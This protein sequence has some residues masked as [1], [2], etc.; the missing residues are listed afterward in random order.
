MLGGLLNRTKS[1]STIQNGRLWLACARHSVAL[2]KIVAGPV[3]L[4][5]RRTDD[6]VSA[7][8]SRVA[9]RLNQD[10]IESR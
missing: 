7:V 4:A 10:F 8:V 6:H 3:Q 1:L 5:T 9:T 2:Q